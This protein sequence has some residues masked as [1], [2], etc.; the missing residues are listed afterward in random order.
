MSVWAGRGR[1][2]SENA[3]TPFRFPT[4]RQTECVELLHLKHARHRS[5][6][7]NI[8]VYMGSFLAAFSTPNAHTRLGITA[9]PLMGIPT[10]TRKNTGVSQQHTGKSTVNCDFQHRIEGLNDTR[11]AEK[12]LFFNHTVKSSH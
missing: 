9:S 1:G 11:N 4:A 7:G 6:M 10:Y 2:G 5:I 8:Y 12:T 3:F